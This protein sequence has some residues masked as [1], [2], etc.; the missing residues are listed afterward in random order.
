MAI[1]VLLVDTH[2]LLREGIKS[3][4][5]A[6]QDIDFVGEA[7]GGDDAFEQATTLR[8][9]IMLIDV[10]HGNG[11]GVETVRRVK[12]RCPDIQVLL[13]TPHASLDL[14]Q[15]SAA[16]GAIGCIVKD[17]SPTDLA[18]AIRAIHGGKPVIP[19]E[20][21]QQVVEDLAAGNGE[22][23]SRDGLTRRE[24]DILREVTSGMS[25]KEI[26]AKLFLSE[27]SV[28]G[29]LRGIY[30][31]LQIRNRAQAAAFVIEHQLQRE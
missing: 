22:A 31:R 2:A 27:S 29:T 18:D 12:A 9:N 8:P 7:E 4:L 23:P 28:K 24:I 26:G 13:F 30:R 16:A 11:H 17:A 19:P 10:T 25:D 3:A 15:R 20:I 14:F 5:R 6:H 21:A 1:T